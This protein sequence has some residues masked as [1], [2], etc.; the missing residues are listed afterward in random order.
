[1]ATETDRQ[2]ARRGLWCGKSLRL[3]CITVRGR[4]WQLAGRLRQSVSPIGP[5]SLLPPPAVTANSAPDSFVVGSDG[6]S[7]RRERGHWGARLRLTWKM[8]FTSRPI[9]QLRK[10]TRVRFVR[11]DPWFLGE[12]ERERERELI[13]RKHLGGRLDS[14]EY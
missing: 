6:N 11:R 10:K 14:D 5:P 9:C 1:M 13:S 12:R 7:A 8:T 2:S 3:Y 4:I